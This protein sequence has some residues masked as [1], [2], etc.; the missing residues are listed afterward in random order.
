MSSQLLNDSEIARHIKPLSENSFAAFF[1]KIWRKWLSF[2][3][4]F[5]DKRPKLS[6]LIYQ[7]V[8]FIVF[9]Q[10][11]TIFQYLVTL[12]LPMMFGLEL[13]GKEFLWP[14][15]FM[16]EAGGQNWY[17]NLLGYAV[18][19]KIVDGVATSE[20]LIGGGLGYFLAFEIATFL[21][22]C[23][24][25]PLQRNITFKSH[26]NP[27]IQMMWYFIGWVL[28]SLFCN[29]VNSLWLPVANG[30]L[31]TALPAAITNII[32][33]V[34][35]GGISMV[36]FFG[37]FL[38]IF[39]DYNVAMKRLA[40]KL[41]KMKASNASVE[42]IQATEKQ[43]VTATRNASLKNAEIAK[44]KATTNA[45][46]KAMAYFAAVEAAKKAQGTEL[47]GNARANVATRQQEASDAIANLAE[48][49][50]AYNAAIA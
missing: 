43:L 47:E 45:S 13:A 2:W 40:A 23:I 38:I 3:Y 8:F 31:G 33:M 6:K 25:F 44:T 49:D 24:N 1:Q 29:G 50:I 16:Y 12:F 5:S 15:V 48:A 35:M 46:M 4:T 19:Y 41:E 39:P 27:Y 9:S 10:G 36:I 30:A 42:K 17:F 32:T 26:G 7:V 14:K 21:A 20:V 11:V 34:V 28:T 37:I 18:N 22:Q